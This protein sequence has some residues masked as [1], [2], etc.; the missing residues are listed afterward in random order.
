MKAVGGVNGK[1][2]GEEVL[3]SLF[4]YIFD[5]N[6]LKT[7]SWTGKGHNNV[8][9]KLALETKSNITSFITRLCTLSDGTYPQTQCVSDMKYKVI[10]YATRNA[11]RKI[12]KESSKKKNVQK[13][14]SAGTQMQETPSASSS[15][16][17]TVAP[18]G[19]DPHMQQP[20]LVP[21]PALGATA[22]NGFDTRVP[23]GYEQPQ[24]NYY[25][26]NH[27][28]PNYYNNNQ[29]HPHPQQYSQPPY[30]YPS[31]SQPNSQQTQPQPQG[32]PPSQEAHLPANDGFTLTTL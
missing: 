7:V 1:C 10:K 17:G 21:G 30:S 4:D 15:V 3:Y 13:Q 23:R 16:T 14:S 32:A 19:I 12:A 6:F 11:N 26:N 25:N 2:N 31:H 29:Y 20:F 9:D 5:S 28:Q 18:F 24:P 8:R 22:P 27:Y